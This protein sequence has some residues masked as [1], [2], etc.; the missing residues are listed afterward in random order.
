MRELRRYERLQLSDLIEA[1]R[2]EARQSDAPVRAAALLHIA[3]VLTALESDAARSTFEEGLAGIATLDWRDRRDLLE[4]AAMLAAA[5]APDRAMEL[6]PRSRDFLIRRVLQIMLE[7]GHSQQAISYVES[8]GD[9]ETF[10]FS[11]VPAL[12]DMSSDDQTRLTLFQRA[13]ELRHAARF[14][15]F[16]R[17]FAH[18]WTLLPA[19]KARDLARKLVQEQP[20][21]PV[22]ARIGPELQFTSGRQFFLFEI[23]HV[24][25]RLDPALADSLIRDHDQLRVAAERYPFGMESVI[26]EARRRAPAQG[27]GHG[28]FGFAGSTDDFP[29]MP[30]LMDAERDG[31]FEPAFEKALEHFA[32]DTAPASPNRAVKECWPSTHAFRHVL[33]KAGKKLGADAASFLERICDP[34]LRLFAQIEL[35]AA[36][37]GRPQW[38]GTRREYHSRPA[39]AGPATII[40]PKRPTGTED[41]SGGPGGP[42]IRCPKCNWSPRPGDLWSCKCGHQWNTFD[43]GGVCPNCL[44]QRTVTQCLACHEIS[45]HSDW[46][47]TG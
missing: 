13:I 47:T 20:D 17:V 1:A 10:P 12:I 4:E 27:G 11:L 44:Y 31:N 43:T 7:Y 38:S 42:R 25:R 41:L 35:A 19:D 29:F 40:E 8:H 36:L 21:M 30:A 5:V 37:A 32:R 26:Q 9:A 16:A 6:L 46:Y 39:T 45:A 2:V 33:Y 34:D 24:L 15:E 22:N 14:N 3:R 18:H 28:G 23:L